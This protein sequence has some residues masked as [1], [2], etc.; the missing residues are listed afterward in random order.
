M[1]DFQEHW[2]LIRTPEQYSIFFDCC[3]EVADEAGAKMYPKLQNK[4]DG[5]S[6][7]EKNYVIPELYLEVDKLRMTLTGKQND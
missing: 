6:D 4:V 2:T 1:Q 5:Y 7:F 3:T